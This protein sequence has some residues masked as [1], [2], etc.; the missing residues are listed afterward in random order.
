MDSLHEEQ[1]LD[2]NSGLVRILFGEE[3][4]ALHRLSVAP[5]AHCRQIPSPGS[6]FAGA[7]SDKTSAPDCIALST[8]CPSLR[9]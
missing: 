8:N 1:L 5:G 7:P 3:V 4:A 6:P 2:E 9:Y